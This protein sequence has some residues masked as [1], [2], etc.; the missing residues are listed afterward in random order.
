MLSSTTLQNNHKR[1]KV[2]S[3]LQMD[4]YHMRSEDWTIAKCWVDGVARYVLYQRKVC[5]GVW[6]SAAEAVERAKQIR[7]AAQI[8]GSGGTRPG[9]REKGRGAADSGAGV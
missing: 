9:F 8:D 3:W 2:A 5:H 1:R 7:S 6:C 4:K